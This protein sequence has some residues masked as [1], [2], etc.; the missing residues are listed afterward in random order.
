LTDLTRR[1]VNEETQTW[2]IMLDDVRVG[3]IGKRS[4]APRHEPQWRWDCGFYPGIAPGQ[5]QYGVA[6]TFDEARAEFQKAWEYVQTIM[7]DDAFERNREWQATDAIRQQR[8][9]DGWTPPPWDGWMTCACGVRFNS[10]DPEQ[11][12]EHV[13]H[14]EASRRTKPA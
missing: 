11:S 2:A 12:Q 1:L 10:W 13:P 14:I 4:G 6:G 3:A 8:I 7:P 9:K 5:H